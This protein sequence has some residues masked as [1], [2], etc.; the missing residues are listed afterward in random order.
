MRFYVTR[1]GQTAW[2]VENIVCGSTDLPLNE[3]GEAQARETAALLQH[4]T[5]DRVFCSPLLRA[6]QTAGIICQGR[7]IPLTIDP[8]LREQDY[9]EYEGGSRFDEGFLAHKKSFATRYPGGESHMVTGPPLSRGDRAGGVPRQHLPGDRELFPRYDQRGVFPVFHGQLRGPPVPAGA[10][11]TGGKNTMV[12]M[13]GSPICP[14]CV[15][16]VELFRQHGF[17][18][19]DYK[20]ITES[21]EHL[22]AFLHLRDT[23]VELGPARAAG[24]IGIPC[25]VGE[26]GS[27]TLDAAQVLQKWSNRC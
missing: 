23:R 18:G 21:T 1:H 12:T 6:R 26:D 14:D 8:R 11:G 17:T 5:F 27:L 16:A 20:V 3:T 7:D 25:F 2:N 24:K 4:V 10:P 15:E 13:Y 22:K 19:Y 9:G